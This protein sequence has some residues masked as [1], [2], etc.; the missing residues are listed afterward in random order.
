MASKGEHTKKLFF[1]YRIAK[2]SQKPCL[3]SFEITKDVKLMFSF[4]GALTNHKRF[5]SISSKEMCMLI[6][7]CVYFTWHF[8]FLQV[9]IH[10]Y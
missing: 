3:C 5:I 1:Y 4:K 9:L 8:Y 6:T 2:W 10:L 7:L